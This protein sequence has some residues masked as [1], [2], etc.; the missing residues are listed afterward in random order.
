MTEI[1]EQLLDLAEQ[2]LQSASGGSSL[3]RLT[4][5]GSPGAAVKRAE[6]Q[7]AALKELARKQQQGCDD[8]LSTARQIKE[9]WTHDLDHWSI[10]PRSSWVPYRQG[11]IEA[12]ERFIKSAELPDAVPDRK[13]VV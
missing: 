7:W 11:G 13:S 3:C 5:S 6:G 9:R 12:L 1:L 8:Y 2:E 10:D 4:A